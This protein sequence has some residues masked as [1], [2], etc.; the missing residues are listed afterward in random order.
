MAERRLRSKKLKHPTFLKCTNIL[1]RARAFF[2][3]TYFVGEENRLSVREPEGETK[4]KLT[5]S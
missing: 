4:T 5:A 2:F 3:K 1:G